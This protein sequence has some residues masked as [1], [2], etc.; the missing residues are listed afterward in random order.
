ME[1]K[2][3][4]FS[5]HLETRLQERNLKREW[6]EDTLE[7]PDSKEEVEVEFVFLPTFRVEF[8]EGIVIDVNDVVVDI[9][10]VLFKA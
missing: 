3:F 7:N 9:P 4:I 10:L 5:Q 1:R 6:V 2:P 8:K